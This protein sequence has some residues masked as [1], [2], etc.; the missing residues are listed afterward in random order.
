MR[1]VIADAYTTNKN[2]IVNHDQLEQLVSRNQTFI[3][4]FLL[5]ICCV[6]VFVIIV[7]FVLLI[8][9]L[10]KSVELAAAAQVQRQRTYLANLDLR[11]RQPARAVNLNRPP[12]ASAPTID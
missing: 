5:I 2:S 6:V 1:P 7:M 11:A 9:N 8:F 4:D 3:R 12:P 10:N